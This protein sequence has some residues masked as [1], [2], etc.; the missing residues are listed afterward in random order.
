MHLSVLLFIFS[1]PSG[2]SLFDYNLGG[3]KI[4]V[5]NDF[6]LL[7][8]VFNSSLSFSSHVDSVCNKFLA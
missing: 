6:K 5:L 1:R 7:G 2:H 3:F 4:K 8:V